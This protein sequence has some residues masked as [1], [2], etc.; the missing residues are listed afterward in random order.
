MPT[1][2]AH[3]LAGATIALLAN[4]TVPLDR[5]L[6]VATVAAASL[7][8]ID[9]GISY[10]LGRNVHHHFTHG[11]GCAALFAA[12]ALV[13][14]RALAR[15]RPGRDALILAVAY[16][17]HLGLDLFSR[18]TAPPYGLQLLWPFT[19]AFYISPILLFDDVWRGT[20]AKLF[21]MHNWLAVSREI[22]IVGPLTALVW[23]WWRRRQVYS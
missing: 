3:T 14:S 16:L 23:V 1:P 22:L 17:S 15:S 19:D 9:F 8:D 7:P 5:N 10:L 4:R 20:L 18:D 21:G 13:V 12:A 6:F 11:V 2:V